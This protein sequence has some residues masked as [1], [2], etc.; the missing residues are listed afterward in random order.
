MMCS[1]LYQ[2]YIFENIFFFYYILVL[3]GNFRIFS[4]YVLVI[5]LHCSA[6]NR[7]DRTKEYKKMAFIK[8]VLFCLFEFSLNFYVI[9]V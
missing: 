9:F 8:F 1:F 2:N 7:P 5:E 6:L 3:Y 4:I